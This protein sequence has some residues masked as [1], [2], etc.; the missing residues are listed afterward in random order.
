MMCGGGECD[1]DECDDVDDAVV[2]VGN[3]ID[4]VAGFILS[5]FCV[6]VYVRVWWLGSMI[7]RM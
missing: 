7:E 6:S 5:C 3:V 4:I 1:D 2:I